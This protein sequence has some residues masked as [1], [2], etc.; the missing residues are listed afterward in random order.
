MFIF[1][2]TRINYTLHGCLSQQLFKIN[3][4]RLFNES[5]SCFAQQINTI[6]TYYRFNNSK[7][8]TIKKLFKL[9][10]RKNRTFF[11][12]NLIINVL[13]R[14]MVAKIKLKRLYKPYSQTLFLLLILKYFHYFT[15][16]LV[17]Y[18]K[19]FTSSLG[20][21]GLILILINNKCNYKSLSVN[22]ISLNSKKLNKNLIIFVISIH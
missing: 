20:K 13:Y 10:R 2:P 9:L 17:F 4:S 18:S 6:Q 16:F 12:R 19:Y 22:S 3:F 8:Y 5:L 21:E 11:V 7:N 1:L 15:I 14:K